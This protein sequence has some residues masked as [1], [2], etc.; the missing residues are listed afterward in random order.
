MQQPLT[1]RLGCNCGSLERLY[2]R[3]VR[4]NPKQDQVRP[5][6]VVALVRRQENLS[7]P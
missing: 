4:A 5:L 1:T 3:A 7:L 6:H 2:S